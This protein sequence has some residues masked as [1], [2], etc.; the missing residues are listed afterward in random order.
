M[1]GDFGLPGAFRVCLEVVISILIPVCVYIFFIHPELRI[2]GC[3]FR[4]GKGATVQL[5]VL[6]GAWHK[7]EPDLAA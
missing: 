7:R 3:P 1:Y 5:L 4:L 2:R 6:G